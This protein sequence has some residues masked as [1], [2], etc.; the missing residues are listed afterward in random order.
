[1][2][3]TC[4]GFGLEAAV[5]DA[6]GPHLLVVTELA[7]VDHL[8]L[9]VTRRTMRR[10]RRAVHTHILS[11]TNTQNTHSLSH[12]LSH[13]LTH[14]HSLTRSLTHT[15]SLSLPLSLYDTHTSADLEQH[16]EDVGLCRL[17][18]GRA[19]LGRGAEISGGRGRGTARVARIVFGVH[20]GDHRER[21]R[22]S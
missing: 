15:L 4:V 8:V 2:G 17:G 13:S 22:G 20:G 21:S 19:H 10:T 18:R 6:D 16:H 14:F 7:V 11:H 3:R 1:M 5:G 9:K 12:T